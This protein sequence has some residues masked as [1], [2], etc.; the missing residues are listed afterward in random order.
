MFQRLCAGRILRNKQAA[1]RDYLSR[2]ALMRGWIDSI[3]TV[4]EYSDR[5]TFDSVLKGSSV[6]GAI[7]TE[8]ETANDGKPR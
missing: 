8:R 1:R 6:S 2:Q 3:E 7:N 4:G 5:R